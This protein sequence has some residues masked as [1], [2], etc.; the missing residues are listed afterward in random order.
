ML[1]L[2]TVLEETLDKTL[3]GQDIA[4]NAIMDALYGRVGSP[5]TPKALAMSFHGPTGTGKTY[6]AKTI[7]SHFYKKGDL[8]KYCHYFNGRSDFPKDSAPDT[9]QQ[10]K[11]CII[12]LNQRQFFIYINTK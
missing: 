9:Y 6:V 8:S 11:V 4:K 10:Y 7:M 1:S 3:F 12:N 2:I 5:E